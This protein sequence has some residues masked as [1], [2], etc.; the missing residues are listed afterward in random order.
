MPGV[1]TARIKVYI[2]RKF[3]NLKEKPRPVGKKPKP[4]TQMDSDQPNASGTLD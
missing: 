4:N 3:R 1:Q 2:A